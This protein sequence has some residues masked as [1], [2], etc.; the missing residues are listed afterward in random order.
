MEFH[1]RYAGEAHVL[2]KVIT[3]Y[4][5]SEELNEHDISND[6]WQNVEDALKV[7]S[8]FKDYTV[9]LSKSKYATMSSVRPIFKKV[10]ETTSVRRSRIPSSLSSLPKD[11]GEIIQV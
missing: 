9:Y 8:K 4:I 10:I 6:D 3:I 5:A 11:T 7:L 2:R 1:F